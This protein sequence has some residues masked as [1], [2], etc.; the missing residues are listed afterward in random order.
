[1]LVGVKRANGLMEKNGRNNR[2]D[3]R[4]KI[5][6]LNRSYDLMAERATHLVLKVT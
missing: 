6:V 1:M 3:H 5:I 4:L 2:R